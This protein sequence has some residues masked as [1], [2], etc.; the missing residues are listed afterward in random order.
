MNLI[1]LDNKIVV[2]GSNG[3]A[4]RAICRALK[5]NG[6]KKILQ[7]PRDELDLANYSEGCKL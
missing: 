7:P 3:M 5:K 2:F 1:S 4:G 6:Y